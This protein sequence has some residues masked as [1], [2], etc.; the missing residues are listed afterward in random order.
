VRQAEHELRDRQLRR[1][2]RLE[3]R[4]QRRAHAGA[5]E[6]RLL[7]HGACEKSTEETSQCGGVGCKEDGTAPGDRGQA[8][9]RRR[10]G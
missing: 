3:Q 6:V 10:A 7:Q 5:Q 8:R 2:R 4:R 1:A 9:A